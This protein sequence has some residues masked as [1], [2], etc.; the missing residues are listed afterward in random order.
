MTTAEILSQLIVVALILI[1]A[2]AIIFVWCP[3]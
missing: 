3:L 2:A 1:C